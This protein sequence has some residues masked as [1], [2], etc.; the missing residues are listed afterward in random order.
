MEASPIDGVWTIEFDEAVAGEKGSDWGSK[1]SG[2]GLMIVRE[3][4]REESRVDA[5]ENGKK[6]EGAAMDFEADRVS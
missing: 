5:D 4:L 6:A 3:R 1:L 2:R